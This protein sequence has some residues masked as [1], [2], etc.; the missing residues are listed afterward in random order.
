MQSATKGSSAYKLEQILEPQKPVKKQTR[1]SKKNHRKTKINYMAT[2]SAVF[3]IALFICSRYVSIYGM[4]HDFEN[5]SAQLNKL[6]M[7]NEQTT[8]AIDSMI[9]GTKVEEY[10]TKQLGMRKIENSQ[11]VYIQPSQGD[12]MQKVAN[13]DKKSATKGIFGVIS[14]VME[15]LQ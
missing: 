2:I 9:D 5:K 12:S 3:L 14:G 10:A 4:H 15:Y 11:I 13:N 1:V 7:D 8:L 6:K